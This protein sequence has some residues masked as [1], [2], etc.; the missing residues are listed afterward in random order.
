MKITHGSDKVM[1]G[2]L[3]GRTDATDYFYFFCPSCPNDNIL[4]VLDYKVIR[5]EK[6]NKNNEQLK[7]KAPK[8]FVILFEL[9]CKACGHRDAVKVSNV[10]WQG[11][12]HS[13]TLK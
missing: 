3:K 4:R 9:F 5:E 8:S 13:S 1:D 12:L 2:A 6:G 10:G 11:G 7:S